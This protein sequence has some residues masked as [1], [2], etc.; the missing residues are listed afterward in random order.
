MIRPFILCLSLLSVSGCIA[1]QPKSEPSPHD[2]DV[3]EMIREALKPIIPELRKTEYPLAS[4]QYDWNTSPVEKEVINLIKSMPERDKYESQADYKKRMA[5]V[6][7]KVFKTSTGIENFTYNPNT[8][9]LSIE[10]DVSSYLLQTNS[11]DYHE[12]EVDGSMSINFSTLRLIGVSDEKIDSYIGS[13]AYGV[14]TEV[15]VSEFTTSRLVFDKI[16]QLNYSRYLSL[17]DECKIPNNEFREYKD[18]I[19][20]EVLA[21]LQYPYYLRGYSSKGATL[22]SPSEEKNNLDYLRGEILAARLI[23]GQTGE[24]YNCQ[25]TYTFEPGNY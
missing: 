16:K 5:I 20:V 8:Q 11:S 23:N 6:D 13:N 1:N 25:I 18:D 24:I 2:G 9:Q 7:G 19:Q 21:K 14:T 15:T 17:N 10:K 12:Y 3:E 4:K 22:D